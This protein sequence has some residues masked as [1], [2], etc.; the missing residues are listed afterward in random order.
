VLRAL[1]ELGYRGWVGLEC[2]PRGEALDAARAVARAD[3]W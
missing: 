1:H 2:S 3:Q